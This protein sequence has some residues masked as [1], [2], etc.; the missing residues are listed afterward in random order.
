MLSYF[1][2]GLILGLPAAATPGPFQAYLLSQTLKNGWQRTLPAALAP[3][4]S[5]G[6]II[7]LVLLVLTSMP[8]S[9]LAAVKVIGGLFILYL[10]WGAW[11]SYRHFVP[12]TVEGENR[13]QSLLEASMMN[14]LNPAPYLYWSTVGGPLLLEGWRRGTGEGVGFLL[15]F[16][17]TMVGGSAL[18]ILLFAT[19]G[20]LGAQVNRGLIGFSTVALALFGLYQ[21]WSGISPLFL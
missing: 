20:R 5:D 19:A 13:R 11:Q 18:L 9:L 12:A 6:P 8:P 21:L 2:R 10:S 3:L 17:G 15:G 7:A 14:L 4:F 1:F 16:Y